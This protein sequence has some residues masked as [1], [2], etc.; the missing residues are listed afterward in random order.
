MVARAAVALALAL[1]LAITTI[2]RA[3]VLNWGQGPRQRL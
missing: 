2:Q 3:Q 1:A